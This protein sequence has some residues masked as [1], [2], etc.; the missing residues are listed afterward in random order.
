MAWNAATN[1]PAPRSITR[2]LEERIA[3]IEHE[4]ASPEPVP[5]ST[6]VPVVNSALGDVLSDSAPCFLGL[7]EK[8]QLAG[9]VAIPTQVPSVH[10]TSALSDLNENHPRAVVNQQSSIL[11][12]ASV[13]A[14]VAD[15]LFLVY[16][17]RIIHQYPILSEQEVRGVFENVMRVDYSN[18]CDARSIYVVSLVM[19][20]SLSTAARNKLTRAKSLA[21]ALFKNAMLKISGVLTNDLA[22]LQA[23]LLLI[24]YTF[25]NPTVGNL[26]LLTG[27]SSEACIELGLHHE[28]QSHDELESPYL[29]RRRCIFWC[30]WEM[31]IAV[32]AAFRRPI[33]TLTK[34]I[35]I[36]FPSP[37]APLTL[38]SITNFIWSFR[39]LEAELVSILHLNNPLPPEASSL[40]VWME[41]ME[42]KAHHWAQQVQSSSARNSDISIKSQWCEMV[43]YADIAYHY[44]L[45]LIY[46]PSN[47]VKGPTRPNLIRAFR[48][49]VR[50][51]V[52]YWEQANSEF[53]RIKYTFHTCYHTFSAAVVF[54]SVLRSCKSE[55][56]QLF[57]LEDI[58]EFANCFSR[59]FAS[60][61]E[62]WPAAAR[63]LGEYDQLLGPIMRFYT[64]FSLTKRTHFDDDLFQPRLTQDTFLHLSEASNI[65]D[66]E[67]FMQIFNP[68]Q[69]MVE[70]SPPSPAVIPIDWDMEFQFGINGLFDA[71]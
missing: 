63:C 65:T 40:E 68:Q 35:T 71:V 5:T 29:D 37:S 21:T 28:L 67:S 20:I 22:G 14:H 47:R 62:R 4:L 34:Y 2:Y 32:S 49:S 12:P 17:T 15:F 59:L 25:L 56:T 9:C 48:A 8:S 16:T 70:P 54:L 24:Q 55:I 31:E 45:V 3:A 41:N 44:S 42:C 64:G 10:S 18:S 53:G 1:E 7:V 50:V 66:Y 36:N 61:G 13:P 46:G 23:L 6:L 30:A 38:C 58:Q 69:G 26:W 33:R 39:Q 27:L 57:T 19:A 52:S 60:L 51:A 11:S 43:L